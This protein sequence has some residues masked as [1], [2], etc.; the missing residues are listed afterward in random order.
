MGRKAYWIIIGLFIFLFSFGCFI[1]PA[2]ASGLRVTFIIGQPTYWVNEQTFSMDAVPF[3]SSGRSFVPLRYLAY[4]LN[5]APGNI[6]WDGATGIVTLKTTIDSAYFEIRLGVHNKYLSVIKRVQSGEAQ[7]VTSVSLPMDVAPL[8]L[9]GRVYLP[10]RYVAEA[11]GYKVTWEEEGQ[12]VII[13]ANQDITP[14]ETDKSQLLTSYRG[15]QAFKKSYLWDY[16]GTQYQ[17]QIIVPASLR[18][19]NKNLEKFLEE[20]NTLTSYERATLLES[21]P[22]STKE[23]L[24]SVLQAPAGD[25]R[26]WV[27]EQMNY[28]YTN[29]LALEL[30]R[31]AAKEG[32][33]RFY[34]AEFI[35]SFV[36]SLPYIYT[37]LPRLPATTILEGGDCK[38]KSI[39]LA[40]FLKALGYQVALLEFP[41][42]EFG[43]NIGHEAVGIAFDTRELPT[44]ESLFYFEY[45][46]QRYYYAE[47][48][49]PGWRLGEMPELLQNK[50]VVVYSL[51]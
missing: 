24:L 35:L 49:T 50:V 1:A 21:L 45:Q 25:F 16:R 23:F 15:T 8:L 14:G 6:S 20:W 40:G 7:V 37:P 19:Y 18:E 9:K 2:Y 44:R 10:A 36:Q 43:N 12:K 31:Q 38:S 41:P 5:V 39:L 22:S 30:H 47:T 46:G 42:E 48:T 32:Y 28:T 33:N 26:P 17:W 11:L 51:E 29:N 27:K 4:A 34:K 13:T 3:L